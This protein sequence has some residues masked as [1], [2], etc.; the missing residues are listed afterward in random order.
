MAAAFADIFRPNPEVCGLIPQLKGR[1]RILL[2]SNTN[3]LHSSQFIKQF[4]DVL[5]HFDGL[6]LSCK[7]QVRKP[8]AGFFQHCVS[9]ADCRAEECLFIDDMPVNISG[10][11]AVG[12]KGLVYEPRGDLAERLGSFGIRW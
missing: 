6:V 8:A 9:L 3:E 10:A 1:Y 2:G 5:S 12:L 11:Q 7:I 4:K